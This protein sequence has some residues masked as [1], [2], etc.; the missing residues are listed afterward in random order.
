VHA[1]AVL[2]VL[3]AIWV[4]AP[5]LALLAAGAASRD[6]PAARRMRLAVLAVLLAAASLIFYG[7]AALYVTRPTP[8]FVLAA[9]VKWVLIGLA[10]IT[11]R[12]PRAKIAKM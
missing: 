6:W 7:I 3:F 2:L 4:A 11:I 5:F 12:E 10:F 8:V 1:P 9:P